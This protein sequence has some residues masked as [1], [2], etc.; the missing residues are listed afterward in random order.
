M[1]VKLQDLDTTR[2]ELNNKLCKEAKEKAKYQDNAM[3]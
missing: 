2:T 3:G 1:R